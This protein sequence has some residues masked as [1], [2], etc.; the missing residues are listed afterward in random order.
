[1]QES[2]DIPITRPVLDEEGNETGETVET[3]ETKKGIAKENHYL[4]KMALFTE[5]K[6]DLDVLPIYEILVQHYPKKQYWTQL[7]GLY[8]QKERTL[9]QMGALEAAYD[10]GLLDLVEDSRDVTLG[11][12]D[13]RTPHQTFEGAHLFPFH[14]SVDDDVEIPVDSG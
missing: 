12:C 2:R 13:D 1:M 11:D 14:D 6:R 7:S 4:L 9:D 5:L 8:G 3:G 10:D